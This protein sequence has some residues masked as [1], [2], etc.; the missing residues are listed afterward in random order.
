MVHYVLSGTEVD[1]PHPAYG[2][3]L[4]LMGKVIAA[5]DSG[6]HALLEAPT[7]SGKTAALL[8]SALAWQ[9]RL[10]K[11]ARDAKMDIGGGGN[12]G[13]GGGQ[14][15][16]QQPFSNAAGPSGGGG[17]GG[18]GCCGGAAAKQQQ[19]QAP[20]PALN[21]EVV[22]AERPSSR[23]RSMPPSLAAAAATAR[24]VKPGFEEDIVTKKKKSDEE[25]D[26]DIDNEGFYPRSQPEAEGEG[27][28]A[29]QGVKMEL[30]D[31]AKQEAATTKATIA[32]AEAAAGTSSSRA[33]AA[34]TTTTAAD[35]KQKPPSKPPRIF[36]TS[37]T[38][39]QIAQVVREL[40]RTAYRPRTAML[41][42]REHL[43]V[44]P[45]IVARGGSNSSSA[46][47]GGSG[48]EAFSRNDACDRLLTEN[49]CEYFKGVPR[50]L[51]PG[52][53]PPVADVE[54]LVAAGKRAR[55]C[56][57]YASRTLAECADLVLAPYS[58]VLDP[59]VR[60]S[61]GEAADLS[62]A[63]VIVDEAHN[64]E[65]T[66]REA[67]SA[68]VDG[69]QLVE[70]AQALARAAAAATQG[71]DA[72]A[73]S[74]YAPL[75]ASVGGVAAWLRAAADG[76]GL[77]K[78]GFESFERVWAGRSAQAALAEAGLGRAA[79]KALDELCREARQM[80][81]EG[82]E[83]GG[84][85][86]GSNNE[87]G[88]G[89]A[90]SAEATATNST[91]PTAGITAGASA[92]ACLNRLLSALAMM[93]ESAA[94]DALQPAG[95]VPS[96]RLAVRKAVER[97]SRGGG[98][99]HNYNSSPEWVPWLCVWALSPEQAFASAAAMARCFILAS[100]TL[101]PTASFASELGAPFPIRLEAPH[102]VDMQR[103]V[104]AGSTGAAPLLSN[105][106]GENS[107]NK[108]QQLVPLTA[109]FKA[110]ASFAFQDGVAACLLSAASVV[111]GGILAFFPSYA[112]LD[113]LMTRWRA[114]GDWERICAAVPTF[115]E[116]RGGGGGGG[117]NNNGGGGGGN[118][119]GKKGGNKKGQSHQ[120]QQQQLSPFDAAL[121]GYYSAI[122]RDR[123]R[124]ALFL[125]VCRGKASEGL[126]FADARARAVLVFGVP[127]PSATSSQVVA[128][129]QFND[130]RAQAY[131][132]GML[133]ALSSNPAVGEFWLEKKKK[134]HIEM[135]LSLFFFFLFFSRSR[136]LSGS[137]GG[138]GKEKKKLT[139]PLFSP[140]ASIPSSLKP[141]TKP[142]RPLTGDQW[143]TQQAFR[144][145][146][147]AVGR[148]IRHRT[149]WGAV[150]LVDSRFAEQ[151]F[152]SPL[153]RW[154]RGSLVAPGAA[155][156]FGAVCEAL[157]PFFARLLAD[158]PVRDG[159]GEEEERE[160]TEAAAAARNGGGDKVA[161]VEGWD[162]GENAAPVPKLASLWRVPRAKR[163][164]EGAAA[165]RQQRQ[166]RLQEQQRLQQQQQAP[167]SKRP[168]LG[169]GR[170]PR[171]QRPAAT[172]KE[173]ENAATAAAAAGAAAPSPPPRG[174]KEALAA[175][176]RPSS[177]PDRRKQ[178][179][180]G[181]ET[182]VAARQPQQ[183]GGGEARASR[184][185]P[186]PRPPSSLSAVAP[187]FA[188]STPVPP[189]S[190]QASLFAAAA[191]A[192]AQP[193]RGC[194][195]DF[196]DDGAEADDA[197]GAE[198]LLQQALRQQQADGNG[199]A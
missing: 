15:Q 180:S 152:R 17:C 76:G 181:E 50:L 171:Q 55:S 44:H 157:R 48:G 25:D 65:D 103:Q 161:D 46:A 159:G 188:S 39:S 174:R 87:N 164:L 135:C 158:P 88:G 27:D 140:L 162:D 4:V 102:V 172:A 84:G 1:F 45:K 68:E 85:G 118:G 129:R 106:G 187:A 33:A 168:A 62:N 3:Q 165:A 2:T 167:S 41:A 67:A 34:A 60:G 19:Q 194:F 61:L 105:G 133:P 29:V 109:T 78:T 86:T 42:S 119:R 75:A 113:R 83:R 95:G 120:Q 112:A 150:V 23:G 71:G 163:A 107:N 16:Q 74:V 192:V 114:T 128:K 196:D 160:R 24:A 115:F 146:N 100:G 139:R 12:G 81:E 104:W 22:P 125:A 110:A 20:P 148:C 175:W 126:D 195:G 176:A 28:A 145:L 147:Q 43:C 90:T 26:D 137:P 170:E 35:P 116:P 143:Y 182:A 144:A 197:A 142:G 54:E 64:V 123:N 5:A 122:S 108:Q 166:P 10:K 155:P 51:A 38:H 138:G 14:Q 92:L 136:G 59:C 99:S 101:A 94:Q 156:H 183:Q 49:A 40:K 77:V 70:A 178:G 72:R 57:Y 191:A 66:C 198:L 149:D 111:P 189:S 47:A 32:A 18:G 179:S 36:Y 56:P 21:G 37:R 58:Y 130:L 9:G 11:E 169:D 53:L 154:L 30:D 193:A 173:K 186:P 69:R 132:R 134:K 7:G 117:G 127:F 153:P 73:A 79:V 13:G 96:F 124:P 31:D 63:L 185:P 6:R 91:P 190:A 177:Q 97:G 199:G 8:C 98:G 52:A 82:R 141:T 184:P 151:R 93:H 131:D 121:K 80:E 89:N